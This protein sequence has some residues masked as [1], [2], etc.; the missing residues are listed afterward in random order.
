[1]AFLESPRRPLRRE[2]LLRATLVHE[3]VC[4]RSVD[5]HVLRRRLEAKPN[6]PRLIRTERGVGYVFDAAV[7]QR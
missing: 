6:A 2:Y 3:D 7:E 5:V 1:M 4:D